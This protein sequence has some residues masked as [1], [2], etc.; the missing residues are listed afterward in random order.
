MLSATQRPLSRLAATALA[1]VVRLSNK[2]T[3]LQSVTLRS[4]STSNQ[5]KFDV[6][7]W[8]K[9]KLGLLGDGLQTSQWS[10]KKVTPPQGETGIV[11]WSYGFTHAA[12]VTDAGNVYT[13]GDGKYFKL[14]HGSKENQLT[15]KKV[16]GLSNVVQVR[17]GEY[18]TA[19]LTAT[20]DVYTWGWGGSFLNSSGAL[21]HTGTADVEKPKKVEALNGIKIVQIAS[22]SVH[23]LALDS[24]G[25]VYAW[26]LGEF[27]R[28]G[29][30]NSSSH[31][32]PVE[33]ETFNGLARVEQIDCSTAYS[34]ARLADGTVMTW[35][36]NEHGQLGTSKGLAL[37][38]LHLVP[39]PSLVEGALVDLK[40]VDIA[41]GE[42][43][44]L[45]CTTE[46]RLFQWGKRLWMEP[47]EMRGDLQGQRIVKVSSGKDVSG[48]I[49]M[50]G[51]LFTWGESSSEALGFGQGPRDRA[52]FPTKLATFGTAQDLPRVERIVAG[53]QQ[54]TAF[55]RKA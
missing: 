22:G 45:A 48:A 30:G 15:P 40:V 16:E 14:G 54:L 36:R 19:A 23:M 50:Y 32:T 46:G 26:G 38:V 52:T 24:D 11:D 5:P 43:F 20:G 12:F 1:R 35:G 42:K 27:G 25:K 9:N 31:S 13:F 55:T 28:L 41:C 33:V 3:L 4:F 47:H 6:Y 7:S 21:G 17:C 44:M 39:T 10:P 18:Q 2:Q 29:V 53:R 51:E 49:T 8:G 34:A 37:D